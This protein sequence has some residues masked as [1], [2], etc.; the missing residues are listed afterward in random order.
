[1]QSTT[2]TTRNEQNVFP[3]LCFYLPFSLCQRG[4]RLHDSGDLSAALAPPILRGHHYPP[5]IFRCPASPPV[6]LQQ[7]RRPGGPR[8]RHAAYTPR[9]PMRRAEH[10]YPVHTRAAVVTYPP[11]HTR[12]EH[13]AH[14][15][16]QELRNLSTTIRGPIYHGAVLLAILLLPLNIYL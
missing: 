4:L 16:P 12:R 8:K 11:E 14:V 2:S 5:P 9:R 10:A 6:P 1:H 15:P 7:P 3:R 13:P